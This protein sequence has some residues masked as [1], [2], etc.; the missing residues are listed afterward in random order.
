[1]ARSRWQ[2]HVAA[3]EERAVRAA[4]LV[5]AVSDEDCAEFVRRYGAPPGKVAVIENGYDPLEARPP[6]PEERRAARA[7]LGLGAARALLFVGSDYPHNRLA[8]EELL[9]HV[10]PKLGRLDAV[11]L[12]A[13]TVSRRFAARA[14]TQRVRCLGELADLRPVLRAADVALSPVTTGAGSNVKLPMYLAAGL[15]VVSTPFGVRGFGRLAPHVAQAPPECFAEVLARA[16]W[17]PPPAPD[18]LASYAWP[19]L[20]RKLLALYRERLACAS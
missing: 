12:L 20:G 13:G 17:P 15:P 11:L 19:A 8:V 2:R 10:V 3:L 1:V 16:S 5:L 9:A 14:A 4:D 18:V 6:D 7:L